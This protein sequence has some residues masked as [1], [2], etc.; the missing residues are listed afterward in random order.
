MSKLLQLAKQVIISNYSEL[1]FP[2][3][4]TYILTNKCQFK[5]A[6]CNIWQKSAENELSLGEI[7]KFFGQSNSFSWINLSGGEIF[8]RTDLP[9]IIKII[10]DNC[11]QLYLLDF[12]T[13]G[14]QT[15]IIV[16]IVK[17]ILTI[18]KPPKLLVTISLDGPP[19]L[20]DKIRNMAGSWI[21]AVETFKQLR[22]LRSSRFDVYFGMTL[23][24]LNVNKIYQTVQSV[25]NHIGKIGYDDF[26][27]NLIQYSPHYYANIDAVKFRDKQELRAGLIGISRLRKVF[28]FSPVGFL[29]RRYQRLAGV[30]IDRNKTPIPCQAL[31]VS[32]FMDPA[33]NVYPCSIYDRMIGNIKDFD[34]DIF[35]L[36]NTASRRNLRK[37]ICNGNCPHCWTPC[38]AYQSI[39]ANILPKFHKG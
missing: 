32:F 3:R 33:G 10:F 22:K 7:K 27:I 26:H 23:Q 16:D 29:E 34:Y 14:F 35:K 12:P 5:C 28:L 19:E 24:P 37:E 18:Y 1:K 20:H 31:S 9:E 39:L 2:Y 4:F 30:Y 25:N 8:L 17:D 36:W 13:N 15:D 38:E 21:K 6:M 11:K